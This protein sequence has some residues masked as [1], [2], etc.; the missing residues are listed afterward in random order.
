MSSLAEGASP[1]GPTP[2]SQSCTSRAPFCGKP[3]EFRPPIIKLSPEPTGRRAV[4][5]NQAEPGTAVRTCAHRDLSLNRLM[6]PPALIHL[7]APPGTHLLDVEVTACRQEAQ[8]YRYVSI[9]PPEDEAS[10]RPVPWS[11]PHRTTAL[12]R[13]ARL[14]NR[15]WCAGPI[16]AAPRS[17]GVQVGRRVRIS[18]APAESP[19]T[20]GPS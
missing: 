18:F 2:S 19:Q 3:R 14:R 4:L 8:R 10:A 11:R 20:L 5:A 17:A 12:L 13:T 7:I 6:G 1:I 9:D 16:W 15:E